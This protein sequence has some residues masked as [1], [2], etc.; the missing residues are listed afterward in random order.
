MK[1]LRRCPTITVEELKSPSRNI[2]C[3]N[4]LTLKLLTAFSVRTKGIVV[5][6]IGI[7]AADYSEQ[8]CEALAENHQGNNS[9][10]GDS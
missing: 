8:G 7:V 3:S 2:Q 4:D 5:A 9:L 10:N 6:F 1:M